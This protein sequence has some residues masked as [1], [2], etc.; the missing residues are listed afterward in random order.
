MA[1]LARLTCLVPG[2][3]W[4]ALALPAHAHLGG[5]YA[6]V[7]ADR[8]H[9]TARIHSTAAATHT[10]HALTLGNG[11]IVKE[12]TRADGTVFAVTWRGPGRP[13][14][15]QLLG[16][17]FSTMQTD[18]VRIGR[19]VRRPMSVK[20]PDLI[21]QSGGHSGAFWGVAILPKLEPPGFSLSDIN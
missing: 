13:D 14:L 2:A 1:S 4:L 19:R 12:Y 20:R 18:N 16:D 6:S 8:A 3:V 21:V 5:P 11:G 7:E 10:V 9:M 15:R 17:H